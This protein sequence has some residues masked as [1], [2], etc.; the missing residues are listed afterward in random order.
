MSRMHQLGWRS[1]TTLAEG[2]A[3]TYE[4]ARPQLEALPALRLISSKT[5]QTPRIAGNPGITM[6]PLRSLPLPDEFCKKKFTSNTRYKPKK[7]G[8]EANHHSF[9]GLFP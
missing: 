2:I 7:I 6:G 3:L 9:F 1:P 8:G 4:A 5:C